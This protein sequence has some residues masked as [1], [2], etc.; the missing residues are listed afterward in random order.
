MRARLSRERIL[1]LMSA[2]N[3]FRLGRPVALKEYQRLLGQ[4]VSG[5]N[6]VS[7][8]SALYAPPPDMAENTS[9]EKGV[10]NRP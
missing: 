5:S 1:D 4:M 3:A 10:E 9:T 6:G 8:R 7:P 2:P